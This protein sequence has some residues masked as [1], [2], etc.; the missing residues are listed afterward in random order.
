MGSF[1]QS[2]IFHDR[3]FVS[4]FT[5]DEILYLLRLLLISYRFLSPILLSYHPVSTRK[6]SD[7]FSSHCDFFQLKSRIGPRF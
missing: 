1:F 7:G 5:P 3:L 2:S 4:S 6:R